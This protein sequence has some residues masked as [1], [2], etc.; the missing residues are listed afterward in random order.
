MMWYPGWGGLGMIGGGII[1]LLFVVGFIALTVWVVK[2][3]V[4]GTSPKSSQSP[5]DIIKARYA[6]GEISKEEYERLKK[7]LAE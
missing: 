2:M 6:R 7:D 4:Q 1:M 3:I 5:L